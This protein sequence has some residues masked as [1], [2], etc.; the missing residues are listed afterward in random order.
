M[1][2]LVLMQSFCLQITAEVSKVTKRVQCA[3]TFVFIELLET[4]ISFAKIPLEIKIKSIASFIKNY[5]IETK[6]A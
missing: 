5:F 2:N 4:A 6:A 1:Q 3:L